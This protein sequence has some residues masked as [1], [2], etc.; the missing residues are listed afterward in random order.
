MLPPRVDLAS[1]A[2][3]APRPPPERNLA[4]DGLRGWA[5]LSVVVYHF[6]YETFGVLFPVFRTPVFHA[7]NG[8]LAVCLFFV[9][10][11]EALSSPFFAGK[12]ERAVAA[13]AVKRLPRLAIP[14]LASSLLIFCIARLGLTA[15]HQAALL[16][17][18]VDWLGLRLPEAPKL[19][20]VIRNSL[21]GTF[22]DGG[23]DAQINPFLWTMKI[24]M[25]GSITVFAILFCWRHV[26]APALLLLGLAA[27][28]FTTFPADLI[29]DFLLGILLAHCRARGLMRIE[30]HRPA[31]LILSAIGIVLAL[32]ISARCHLHFEDKRF[33]PVYAPLLVVSIF[34]NEPAVRFFR[35]APSR[36]LGRISFSLYLNQ[37]AVLVSL[38]SWLIVSRGAGLTEA[39]AWRIAGWSILASFALAIGLEPVEIFTKRFGNVLAA[40]VLVPKAP[41]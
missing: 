27:L 31:I 17:H 21:I 28:C 12:G 19:S 22:S 38:T 32:C 5:A 24:E 18:R 11:G 20:V 10:S 16:V 34:F 9:L 26:R 7:F 25:M 14:V 8:E 15:N 6:C 36:L 2:V 41:A 30:R 40:R 4:L 23:L 29:G 35:S 39:D 37:C 1:P 13:L 33:A 3:D